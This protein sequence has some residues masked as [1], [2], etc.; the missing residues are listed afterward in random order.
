M[1][2]IDVQEMLTKFKRSTMFLTEIY[3][4]NENFLD[5]TDLEFI[6]ITAQELQIPITGFNLEIY[7]GNTEMQYFIF[8]IW[9]KEAEIAAE[10]TEKVIQNYWEEN[11]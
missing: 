5:I 11:L 4:T 10:V 7:K 9:K 8:G 3:Q 6:E 2:D 1:N